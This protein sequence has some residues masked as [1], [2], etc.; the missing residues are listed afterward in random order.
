MT[1]DD[2]RSLG[3]GQGS[4]GGLYRADLNGGGGDGQLFHFD[5]LQ[6]VYPAGQE[7][8]RLSDGR[9]FVAGTFWDGRVE[10]LNAQGDLARTLD[11]G[12]SGATG[13]AV[14]ANEEW[15]VVVDNAQDTLSFVD[16][17]DE[18]VQSTLGV[19]AWGT[20][21]NDALFLNGKLYVTCQGS[22]DLL[23]I[24]S[25]PTPAQARS[26]DG[27]LTVSDS[28]P[29]QGTQ[30]QVDLQ[31]HAGH[32]VV[33]LSSRGLGG[34]MYQGVELDLGGSYQVRGSGVGSWR[35]FCQG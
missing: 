28:T 35:V 34:G 15:L 12:G 22:E 5:D 11:V 16:L 29:R 19:G 26:F 18:R 2:D 3:G 32:P 7:V 8:V 17:H 9:G 24:G 33:L 30:L 25:L 21:P 14:D 23:V 27:T 31:G 4:G 20:Q 1:D 6:Y 10:V 13:L